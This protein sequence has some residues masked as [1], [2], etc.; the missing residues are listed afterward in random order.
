M[1]THWLTLPARQGSTSLVALVDLVDRALED[2]SDEVVLRSCDWGASFDIDELAG[3]MASFALVRR[4]IAALDVLESRPGVVMAVDGRCLGP[5]F[6]LALAVAGR[7]RVDVGPNARLGA[8]EVRYGIPPLLGT[9]ARCLRTL[10]STMAL[11][12]LAHGDVLD[13]AAWASACAAGPDA[14]P[15]AAIAGFRPRP[16]ASPLTP[17]AAAGVGAILRAHDSAP[18]VR[19]TAELEGLAACLADANAHA[20]R[21]RWHGLLA[22]DLFGHAEAPAHVAVAG[23]GHMGSTIAAATAAAGVSV[24]IVGRRAERAAVARDAATRA[25][26]RLE[27][28][29]PL[30]V[31]ASAA[32]TRLRTATSVPADAEAIVEAVAEDAEIKRQVLDAGRAAAPGAWLATTTSSIPLAEIG[33]DV[34]LLHFAFPAEVSPVVEVSYAPAWDGPTAAA[35]GGYLSTLGKAAVAVRSVPG[36]VVSRLLFAYLLEAVDRVAAGVDVAA[37][38][39]A[40]ATAGFAIP[41]LSV[42]DAAGADLALAVADTVLATTYGRR[43]RAAAPLRQIV[44]AGSLGRS[45]G[46][47]FWV[48]GEGAPSPN[49]AASPAGGPPR[50]SEA[51]DVGE[52]LLV[53]VA[54]EARRCQQE[55][56]ASAAAIDVLA[57]TCVRFPI[58]TGGPLAWLATDPAPAQH[59]LGPAADHPRFVIEEGG[60]S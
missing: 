56:L 20:H 38:D 55:G 37:V 3:D 29:G 33:D 51:E 8:S 4:T 15:G 24:T 5:A 6:A 35:V 32:A 31:D 28:R 57:V 60:V 30:R 16:V 46:R 18:G 47:G 48:Y 26:A 45:C 53:A 9:A 23:T 34:G 39:A 52:R 11:G 59:L 17:G 12:V 1:S 44:S 14:D 43:Y 7:G 50:K 42:I 58:V 21:A 40:A 25:L 36:Y 10:P 22:G 19:V 2:R 13:G 54:A 49:P 27:H 41:P